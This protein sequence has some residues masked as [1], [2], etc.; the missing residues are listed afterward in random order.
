MANT[1]PA[2]Q[3][4]NVKSSF[5]IMLKQTVKNW[6]L[7]LMVLPAVIIVILFNYVPMYGV[8]IAFQ[9]Y[10]P[11]LGFL[12]SPWVGFKHFIR[13]FNSYN[14]AL[15]IRNTVLLS[16]YTL[17]WSFPIPVLLALMLNQVQQ[18]KF[19]ATIQTVTYLPYFISTV[20]MVS[21]LNLFLSPER[22][23][24][25]AVTDLLGIAN[26]VNPITDPTLFRSVYIASGIWQG[27]G[28]QSIV[29]LATLSGVDPTLYEAAM[30]DGASKFQRIRH[31]DFPTLLPTVT[32]MFIMACGGLMNVGFEK[33]YLM[34][35]QLNLG[36]SEVLSTYVYKVGLESAQYSFSTAINLFNTVINIFL[37]LLMNWLSDKMSQTSLL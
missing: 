35:N 3:P 2:A 21:I 31:I 29:Y 37:L 34:Q 7:I 26:P 28:F 18:A 8:T 22:G 27:T 13:F 10:T 30:I 6:Q 36:V 1:A 4:K 25:G 15:T 20:V 32:I 16:I 24:F 9:D 12:G 17:L 14:A 5:D 23:F 33:T 11:S 19:K